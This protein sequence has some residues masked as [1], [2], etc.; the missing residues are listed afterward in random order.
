[1]I[2]PMSI[3]VRVCFPSLISCV[4]IENLTLGRYRPGRTQ[5]DRTPPK[6]PS[7]MRPC[8][9][10]SSTLAHVT[11]QFCASMWTP[12]EADKIQALARTIIPDIKMHAIP[13]GLQVEKGPDAIVEYLVEKVPPLLDS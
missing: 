9:D 4:P 6:R 3:T 5:G 12:E 7:E 11:H 8:Q 2:L 1:M 10:L 13:Q